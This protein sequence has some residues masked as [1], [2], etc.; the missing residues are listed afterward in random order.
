MVYSWEGL[1][2]LRQGSKQGKIPPN[3]LFTH[4]VN[5]GFVL[6]GWL[7][8]QVVT[9]SFIQYCPSTQQKWKQ[10]VIKGQKSW[11]YP[12]VLCIEVFRHCGIKFKSFLLG[13]VSVCVIKEKYLVSF[14]LK[15][16]FQFLT[17]ATTFNLPHRLQIFICI[18]EKNEKLCMILDRVRGFYLVNHFAAWKPKHCFKSEDDLSFLIKLYFFKKHHLQSTGSLWVLRA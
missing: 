7:R 11:K 17:F 6:I 12:Y 9:M 4:S 3:D 2:S 18:W 14:Q 8:Q 1:K 10:K 16:Q 15:S 5:K 13:D